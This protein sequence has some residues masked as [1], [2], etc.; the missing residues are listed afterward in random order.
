[1]RCPECAEQLDLDRL[2]CAH[3][4]TF[5]H[6]DG[7]LILLSQEMYTPLRA[8]TERLSAIRQAEGRRQLDPKWFPSLP[9]VEGGRDQHEWRLRRADLAV[10][11]RL[12]RGRGR[13]RVLDVGAW[14][15]WLSYQMTRRGH[16]VTAV[17]YMTDEYDGLRAQKFYPVGWRAIQMDLANLLPLEPPFDCI[18]VNR[19]L[20]FFPKPIQWA[21]HVK[22]LLAPGGLLV[23]TGLQFFVDP[24][25][26]ARAVRE[27]Q[28]FYRD[29]HQ[30]ELF[31]RPTKGY[32]D[33]HDRR[34]LRHTG[35][36]LHSYPQLWAANL[37][38]LV[39]RQLPFHMYGIWRS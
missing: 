35:F 1:M 5:Q 26:K 18:V 6:E 37:K 25:E 22:E 20:P 3:G 14:N 16:N 8:F 9:Y 13:L 21:G 2:T 27:T 34:E 24:R 28:Q 36:Q 23:L 29:N 12:L 33:G 32:L 19:C 10:L 15:G 30:F 4:H 11:V 17:D 7:V 31:F 38:A 39:W